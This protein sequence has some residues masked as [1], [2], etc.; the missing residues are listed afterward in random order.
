[1][2]FFFFFFF[3][4]EQIALKQF[5]DIKVTFL[6]KISLGYPKQSSSSSLPQ[7]PPTSPVL[8]RALGP[9]GLPSARSHPSLLLSLTPAI[10]LFTMSVHS[11]SQ[12]LFNFPPSC[13]HRP[14]LCYPGFHVDGA[15]PSPLCLPWRLPPGRGH[16]AATAIHPYPF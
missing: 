13:P 7:F 10:P 12:Y 3:A 1:M 8:K 16:R 14:L 2:C 11:A 6:L 5:T 9:H 4:T 15:G